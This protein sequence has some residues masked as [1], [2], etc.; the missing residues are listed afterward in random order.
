MSIVSFAFS[1]FSYYS[2]VL[3][4]SQDSSI[5]WKGKKIKLNMLLAIPGGS[6]SIV[7]LNHSLIWPMGSLENSLSPAE[8]AA[9]LHSQVL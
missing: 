4:A 5:V 1:Y 6:F 9:A 7:Y 3:C 8:H 2:H